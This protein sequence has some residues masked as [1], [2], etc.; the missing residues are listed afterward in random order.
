MELLRVYDSVILASSG[1]SSDV[2]HCVIPGPAGKH[3][4]M[5]RA[6]RLFNWILFFLSSVIA[7]AVHLTTPF[8]NEIADV[9]SDETNRSRSLISGG[10][11]VIVEG[12]LRRSDLAKDA[13]WAV[14]ASTILTVLMVFSG[15]PPGYFPVFGL[16]VA[17]RPWV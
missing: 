5:V 8:V 4:S 12:R 15:C 13:S 9:A 7:L 11:G 17:E 3:C 2:Y 10:S 14:V 6:R 1:P 16:R